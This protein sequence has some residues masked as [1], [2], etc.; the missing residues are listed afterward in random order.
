[1]GGG[2]VQGGEDGRR[3]SCTAAGYL[4]G[5]GCEKCVSRSEGCV[6]GSSVMHVF[7]NESGPWGENEMGA[8]ES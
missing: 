2:G 1:M 5:G 4:E 7:P 8:E 3:A 6:E